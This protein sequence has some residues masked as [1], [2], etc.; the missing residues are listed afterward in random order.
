V[1]RARGGERGKRGKKGGSLLRSHS[2]FFG[3]ALRRRRRRR[4]RTFLSCVTC[5]GPLPTCHL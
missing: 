1:T 2:R 4:R 3:E 5:W